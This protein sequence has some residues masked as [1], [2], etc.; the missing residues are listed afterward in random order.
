MLK[1]C[2]KR[3]LRLEKEKGDE[4]LPVWD[5][6]LPPENEVELPLEVLRNMFFQEEGNKANQKDN[7]KNEISFERI[8][9]FIP[10][11]LKRDKEENDCF[12]NTLSNQIILY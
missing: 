5:E 7:S 11:I 6:E 12:Q 4:L 8:C 1:Y 2:L 9:T 10:E 3:R